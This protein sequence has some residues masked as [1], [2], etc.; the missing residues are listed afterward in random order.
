[1][2]AMTVS[3]LYGKAEGR[4]IFFAFLEDFAEPAISKPNEV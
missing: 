2:A 1:M 3:F 4:G